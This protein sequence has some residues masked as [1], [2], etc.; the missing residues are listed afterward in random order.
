VGTD[1][2]AIISHRSFDPATNRHRLKVDHC[3]DALCTAV[4][5]TILDNDGNTGWDSSLKIGSDGLPLI[6]YVKL[7]SAT[8]AFVEDLKVAHCS[9]VVCTAATIS[10]IV[11]DPQ[12]DGVHQA[13]QVT[14]FT[15]LTIGG[16]GKGLIAFIV[17]L[18]NQAGE[19]WLRTAHCE[20]VACTR[21]AIFQSDST[22]VLPGDISITTR[23]DGL[24]LIAYYDQATEDLKVSACLTADCADRMVTKLTADL[25]DFN[26]GT[27][28]ITI[29]RDGLGLIS[30]L[31]EHDPFRSDLVAAH[32]VN[33]YCTAVTITTLDHYQ[34]RLFDRHSS[35]TIGADGL[36]LI[37]FYDRANKDLKVAHCTDAAC[38]AAT[39][40]TLDEFDDVGDGSSIAIGADGLPIISYFDSTNRDLKVAHCADAE[41]K[42]PLTTVFLR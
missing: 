28:L 17:Q 34:S 2:R 7:F 35:I 37:S 13:D 16:D 18:D 29:G 20:D 12:S 19:T 11:G 31:H 10:T 23:P 5:S 25:P 30:Y 4:T 14:D 21:T 24:G 41:C 26:G 36:G 15:S 42:L 27:P 33:L 22:P 8:G 40:T 9:N 3:V 38:T 1:G 32:C 39:V 6:S